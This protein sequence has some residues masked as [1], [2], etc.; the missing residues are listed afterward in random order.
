VLARVL[1]DVGAGLGERQHDLLDPGLGH[2]QVL[3][4]L[5]QQSAHQ[6]DALRVGRKPD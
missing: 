4:G 1:D 2:A 3:E 5:P 6:R